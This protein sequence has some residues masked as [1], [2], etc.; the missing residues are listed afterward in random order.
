MRFWDSSALVPLCLE[1]PATA[2][3]RKLYEG[4]PEMAVW[5]GT[6]VECGS[7]FA[8]LRRDGVLEETQESIAL[9]ILDSLGGL[10]HEI[11]PTAELRALALRLLRV[12]ALRAADALQLAA[13]L[14]WSGTPP[15]GELVTL[16][17][18]LGTAARREGFQVMPSP[19]AP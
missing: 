15:D 3:A 16:D 11:Q 12:H 18:R 9:S 13:G 19:A 8:R 14:A 17:D 4:D 5:W 7:A 1:E 6:P 2:A 10:W